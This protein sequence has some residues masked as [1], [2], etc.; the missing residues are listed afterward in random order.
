MDRRATRSGPAPRPRAGRAARRASPRPT[1]PPTWCASS[2]NCRGRWAASTPAKRDSPR[3][4]WKAIYYHYLPIGVEA[5]APP[6]RAQLGRAAI[7]W[8]AV[9]LADK[10]DT[11]VG[12]FAAGER[13]TG[14]RDPYGLRRAA[15]A[16]VKILADLPATT[17]TAAAASSVT[18]SSAAFA[19]YGG[20]VAQEADGWRTRAFE[21]LGE[22]AAHCSNGAASKYDEIRAVLPRTPRSCKPLEA[23]AGGFRRWPRLANAGVRRRWPCCSSASRTSRKSC[24]QAP[25]P[26]DVEAMRGGAARSRP[27]WRWSTNSSAAGRAIDKALA[28]ERYRDAMAELAHLHGP[29]DRFFTEVLVMAETRRCGRPGWRC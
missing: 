24:E 19:G 20:V 13:P 10:L 29:V 28:S 21:F 4:V 18:W 5:D 23:D 25:S 8:A 2:P 11:I 7:T 27:K 26:D 6:S 1:S 17:G 22:R 16:V 15:Q 12:L 3:Q 9:S 14:S